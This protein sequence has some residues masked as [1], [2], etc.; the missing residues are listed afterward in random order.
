MINSLRL[1]YQHLLD[2]GNLENYRFL[3]VGGSYLF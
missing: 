1:I 2:E 3:Y